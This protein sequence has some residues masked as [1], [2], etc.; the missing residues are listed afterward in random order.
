MLHMVMGFVGGP[1]DWEAVLLAPHRRALA[2]AHHGALLL[3][4]IPDAPVG[5][6]PAVKGKPSAAKRNLSRFA[7]RGG[8]TRC[9]WRRGSDGE[10]PQRRG[11]GDE[12]PR[13]GEVAAQGMAATV[14][15][16]SRCD[17][18]HLPGLA[19]SGQ[20]STPKFPVLAKPGQTPSFAL[21]ELG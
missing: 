11:D 16:E 8:G 5:M 14:R 21:V 2:E 7:V 17:R 6:V 4:S 10:G 20:A 12:G 18:N 1:R 15:R 9:P 19:K 13:Q 3:R